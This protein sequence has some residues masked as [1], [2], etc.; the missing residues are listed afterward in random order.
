LSQGKSPRKKTEKGKIQKKKRMELPK[1][2]LKVEIPDQGEGVNFL[3]EKPSEKKP[4]KRKKKKG[5]S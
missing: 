3:S 1:N 5:P 4:G 2:M